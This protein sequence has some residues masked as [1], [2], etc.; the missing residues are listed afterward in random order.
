M[1]IL[2]SEVKFSNSEY[3]DFNDSSINGG[4]VGNILENDRINNIFPEVSATE[5]QSGG[6]KRSKLFISNNSSDRTM[7]STLLHIK[8]N[9]LAPDKL[10]LFDASENEHLEFTSSSALNGGDSTIAAGTSIEVSDLYP[11]GKT[12][13][14][15]IGRTYYLGTLLVTV[16][17]APDATHITFSDDVTE[18]IPLGYVSKTSDDFTSSED[19]EDFGTLDKFSSAIVVQEILNGSSD[20]RISS[21]VHE[22]F[23]VDDFVLL[24]NEYYQ[25]SYRGKITAMEENSEDSSQ[26]IL[27]LD[28]PY[29]GNTIPILKGSICN[30]LH[31]DLPSG[32]TKSFWLEMNIQ[33]ETTIQAEIL[34]QFQLGIHFDDI[35]NA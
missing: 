4:G 11:S 29:Y 10:V 15:L 8:Q 3:I 35:T 6:I 9:V 16:D 26:W 25:V 23:S 7:Q 33:A 32:R 20:I 14:D 22:D 34:S 5:R 13:N 19:D 30:G 31:F 18:N 2:Y 17:T 12:T 28:N 27:T 21:D 1:S 24:T